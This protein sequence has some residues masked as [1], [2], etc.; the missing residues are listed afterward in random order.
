MENLAVSRRQLYERGGDVGS[1][2]TAIDLH[3]Q[4]L[5]LREPGHPE[6]AASMDSLATALRLRARQTGD[7]KYLNDAIE[8]HEE[9]LALRPEGHPFRPSSLTGLGLAFDGVHSKTSRIGDLERVIYL[10]RQA[11]SLRPAADSRR[12]PAT[13]NL[14]TS[15]AKL[16]ANHGHE[17]VDS[18]VAIES[19]AL[20]RQAYHACPPTSPYREGF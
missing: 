6:R 13:I 16:Y 3:V 10:H 15:L 8:L 1:L 20:F 11:L 2:D 14:A 19:E 18:V 12:L 17:D 4:A 9:A 7:M 5:Q